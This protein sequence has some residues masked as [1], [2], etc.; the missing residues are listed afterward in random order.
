MG[1]Y[2]V[3]Y[4]ELPFHNKERVG[5]YNTKKEA[6]RIAAIELDRA[7]DDRTKVYIG[8]TK[9]GKMFDYLEEY[10]LVVDN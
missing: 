3:V 4:K 7:N 2:Y 6:R 1:S 9:D 5:I 10:S 8:K